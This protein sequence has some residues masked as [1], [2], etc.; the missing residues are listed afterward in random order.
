MRNEA[1]RM[2]TENAIAARELPVPT[3]SAA[4]DSGR[5]MVLDLETDTGSRTDDG[6]RALSLVARVYIAN[7]CGAG[8]MIVAWS[9]QVFAEPHLLL[10]V[11]FVLCALIASTI[12]VSFP[13]GVSTLTLC[14][15]LDYLSL[16]L[17]GPEAAVLVAAVG[18]W[19]QCSLNNKQTPALYQTVFSI[20]SLAVSMAAGAG[21][22]RWLGGEPGAFDWSTSLGPFTAA[23]TVFFLVNSGLVSAAIGLS[24]DKPTLRVWWE[25]CLWS[26]QGYLFGAAI[27]AVAVAGVQSGRYWLV[28]F[29]LIALA[30]TFFNLRA[31]LERMADAQTDPLTGLSNQRAL[32]A[33]L[34]GEI[35]R[36]RRKRSEVAVVIID[37]D[38]FKAINDTH[39]HRAGDQALVKIA[40]SLRSAIG[41]R[42]M[43]ARYAGDEFLMILDRCDAGQA[44]RKAHQLKWAVAAQRLERRPGLRIPLAISVGTAVFPEDGATVDELLAAADAR[45]YDNKRSRSRIARRAGD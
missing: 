35:E 12:K 6:W 18:A 31:Y 42:D 43:C 26:W 17:I 30:L 37:V 5:N 28:P 40:D 7:V 3:T 32:M 8:L 22:Y 20:S 1:P 14:Q 36:A 13:G 29:L 15:V 39:G 16:L 11:G 19:A 24:T 41:P 38:E 10:L 23:A 2:A 4:V 33:H 25:T 27:A 21:V 34:T 45:M 9:L 44:E